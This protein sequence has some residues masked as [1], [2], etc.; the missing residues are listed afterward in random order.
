MSKRWT[1]CAFFSCQ[2]RGQQGG[3]G[4]APPLHV[5]I[6]ENGGGGWIVDLFHVE[7]GVN[8]IAGFGRAS[9]SFHFEIRSNTGR[10][11]SAS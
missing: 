10:A 3:G 5:A 11:S 9:F 7:I 1:G 6:G 2:N 4:V 8:D